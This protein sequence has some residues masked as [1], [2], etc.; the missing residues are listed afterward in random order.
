MR[1]S[2]ATGVARLRAIR[3]ERGGADY[4]GGSVSQRSRLGRSLALPS[5][6]S[7]ENQ[8]GPMKDGLG[9]RS[10]MAGAPIAATYRRADVGYETAAAA[11]LCD[12]AELLHRAARPLSVMGEGVDYHRAVIDAA[13]V[14]VLDRSTWVPMASKVF[15]LGRALARRGAF[16]EPRDLLPEYIRRPEAEELWEK[17]Q[18]GTGS[19]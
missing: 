10:H 13:G 11:Q 1:T 14:A 9:E 12:P 15:A 4:C 8:S 18:K 17:R 16:T 3:G 5:R 2:D 6:R 7:A 19:P